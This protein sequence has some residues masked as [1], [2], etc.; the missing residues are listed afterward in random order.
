MGSLRLVRL[1]LS[2]FADD[3]HCSLPSPIPRAVLERALLS[4]GALC[5]AAEADAVEV[6]EAPARSRDV[7]R[8][9]HGVL[10]NE[11]THALSAVV[12][13]LLQLGRTVAALARR[14]SLS[15]CGFS[16]FF[17]SLPLFHC[18]CVVG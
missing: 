16:F 15:T 5:S 10:L 8:S 17:F 11:L 1:I 14:S 12:R 3:R 13:R 18:V 4:P 7:F 2:F 6:D 9:R